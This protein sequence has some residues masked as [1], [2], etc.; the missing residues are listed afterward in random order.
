MIRLAPRSVFILRCAPRM[1]WDGGESSLVISVM[2]TINRNQALDGPKEKNIDA[3]MQE[4]P[5]SLRD[6]RT[7]QSL[8]IIDG[9][10]LFGMPKLL[11]S[12]AK[13]TRS[14]KTFSHPNELLAESCLHPGEPGV[15]H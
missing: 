2:I 11:G 10:K 7:L 4:G 12:G 6:A 15:N 8:H 14:K 9:L 1:A 5:L 3:E 13:S